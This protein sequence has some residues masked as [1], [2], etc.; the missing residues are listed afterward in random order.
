MRAGA[1]MRRRLTGTEGDH[2]YGA[3]A[4]MRRRH[5]RCREIEPLQHL[6]CDSACCL[7]QRPRLTADPER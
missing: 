2:V 4:R 6:G 3:T 5:W 1:G 7:K